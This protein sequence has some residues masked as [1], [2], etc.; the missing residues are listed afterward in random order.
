MGKKVIITGGS[1]FLGTLLSE[2]LLADG[3]EVVSLDLFPPRSAKVSFV[4][5]DLIA[6]IPEHRYLERPTYIIN[7]AGAPI[8]GRWNTEKKEEIYDSRILGTNH[9]I[10]LITN[11]LYR[12]EALVSASAVGYYGNTGTENVTEKTEPGKGF[13]ARVAADWE[14]AARQAENLGVRTTIIRNSHILGRG[15]MMAKLRPFLGLKLVPQIGPGNVCMSWI[16]EQDIVRLYIQSMAEPTVPSIIN[17]VSPFI[18]TNGEFARELAAAAS[19]VKFQVP[20]QLL[21]L[22]LHDFADEFTYGQC[23]K[24]D[25]VSGRFKFKYPT[26]QSAIKEIISR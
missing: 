21:K 26:I 14:A 8:F 7:L 16:H 18:T 12:P 4:E 24:S 11:P 10:S 2:Q 5:A 19:G 1:G 13:L 20:Q 3:Y 17:A 22:G 9:L 6:G 23:V 25:V 15:G